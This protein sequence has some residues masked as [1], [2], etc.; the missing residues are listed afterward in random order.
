MGHRPVNLGIPMPAL[1]VVEA[2]RIPDAREHQAVLYASRRLSILCQPG[3]GP[4][5]SRYKDEPVRIPQFPA[6]QKPG[7]KGCDRKSR[8]VVVC[9]R[10]V[11]GMDGDQDFVTRP[12]RQ[13]TL[14]VAEVT[15]FQ[16]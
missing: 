15:V 14:P 9:Q 3:D 13:K 7:K 11:T 8:K 6:Q 5:R 2:A 10:W 1:L 12:A 4:D 16:G